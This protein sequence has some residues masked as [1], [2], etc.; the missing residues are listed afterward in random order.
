MAKDRKTPQEKKRL[1]YT[2]D[3]FTFG[4][5]SS[6]MFPRTW[7][8]KKARTNREYRRKTEQLLAQAKP[9]I[10]SRDMPLIADDLT[11]ARFAKSVVR[12]R[13]HKTD[14][15]TLEEKVKLKLERREKTV[16][17]RPK[18]RA[19]AH[20]EA[21]SVIQ[22]LS[23]LQDDKLEDFVRRANV[24][25]TSGDPNEWARVRS[26]KE[27]IDQALYF[28]YRLD[29]G[30][31]SPRDTVCKDERLRKP[32]ADWFT[33]ANRI[34]SRDDRKIKRK[35]EQKQT[36]EKRLKAIRRAAPQGL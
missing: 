19:F 33:K 3:H 23:S 32:L 35:L 16:G 20:Q 4:E 9:G 1:E 8:R 28:I 26:S 2:K 7:K 34:L 6:R 15:V 31:N 14:T 17:R 30:R 12:K 5:H 27:P 18:I 29:S 25:C 36:T 10:A 11:V 22:T 13:L 21:T 24:L